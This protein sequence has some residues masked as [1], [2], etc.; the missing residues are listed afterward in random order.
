MSKLICPGCGESVVKGAPLRTLVGF[1]VEKTRMQ[2]RHKDGEPLC[3]EMT[4]KG[5]QPY[6]PEVR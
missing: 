2:H 5:Y 1:K 6:H 4:S 3:P